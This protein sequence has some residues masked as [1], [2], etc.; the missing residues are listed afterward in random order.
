MMALLMATALLMLGSMGWADAQEHVKF[1]SLA[2]GPAGKPLTIDGYVFRPAD[3]AP[4]PAMV[5]LHGCGGLLTGSGVPVSRE[6]NWAKRLNEAGYVVFMV[7]SFLSAWR[8]ANVFAE[9]VGPKH[10]RRSH[11]RCARRPRIFAD[12]AIRYC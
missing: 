8:E 3:D 12:A 6:T 5:L 9:Y 7:D 4:H 1:A 2:S 10:L 11:T